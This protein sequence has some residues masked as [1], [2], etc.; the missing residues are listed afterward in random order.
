[1]HS[2]LFSKFSFYRVAT[3]LILTPR[4]RRLGNLDK[5][6]VEEEAQEVV[7]KNTDTRRGNKSGSLARGASAMLIKH[8]PAMATMEM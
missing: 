5:V 4:W 1:M 3:T 7:E 8:K 6:E 2:L